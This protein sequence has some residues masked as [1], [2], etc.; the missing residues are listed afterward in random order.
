MALFRIWLILRME[1]IG[2]ASKKKRNIILTANTELAAQNTLLRKQ[3][4]DLFHKY[5]I[6]ADCRGYCCYV[7][8]NK[9]DFNDCYL[10]SY[11]LAKGLSPEFN[12]TYIFKTSPRVIRFLFDKDKKYYPPEDKC[13]FLS[14]AGCVLASTDM[15]NIC[16]S[17]IC[18]KFLMQMSSSDAVR[19]SNL[20][21]KNFRLQNKISY[22]LVKNLYLK[23]L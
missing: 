1:F 9:F 7:K 14:D 10:H 17:F 16:T 15:P 21:T 5:K 20:S 22:S 18:F 3:F 4:H 11:P 12:L 13:K 19:Y 23:T 6:C 2:Q 8:T